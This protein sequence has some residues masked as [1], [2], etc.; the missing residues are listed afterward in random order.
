MIKLKRSRSDEESIEGLAE[1]FGAWLG[2]LLIKLSRA[3]DTA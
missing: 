1:G 2:S 3:P